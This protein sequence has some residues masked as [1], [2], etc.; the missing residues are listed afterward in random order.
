MFRRMSGT[1]IFRI[2]MLRAKAVKFIAMA[3]P[4]RATKLLS[5]DRP[6][7]ASSP[8]I[9]HG[10]ATW[11][12]PLNRAKPTRKPCLKSALGMSHREALRYPN[13]TP[14]KR[15]RRRL[16][17]FKNG[18]ANNDQRNA[19]NA[20]AGKVAL[21]A[22]CYMQLLLSTGGR[23]ILTCDQAA[24]PQRHRRTKLVERESLLRHAQ[25]RAS[26]TCKRRRQATRRSQHPGARRSRTRKTV[27]TS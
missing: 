4:A 21:F 14:T 22:T 16:R 13:T 24:E 6:R 26:A 18:R 7:L 11:S 19:E 27:G 8:R 20:R 3:K 10:G 23:G 9:P 1:W 15:F 5:S 17:D 25:A 12:M 2:T